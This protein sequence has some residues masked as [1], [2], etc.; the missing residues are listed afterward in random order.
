MA[1][2]TLDIPFVILF[3]KSKDCQTKLFKNKQFSH[4]SSSSAHITCTLDY[5]YDWEFVPCIMNVYFD[6]LVLTHS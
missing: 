3:I 2:Y 5:N 4:S 1:R 6:S